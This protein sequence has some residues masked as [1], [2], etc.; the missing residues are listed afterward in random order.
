MKTKLSTLQKKLGKINNEIMHAI[1]V[2]DELAKDEALDKQHQ[3]N[4]GFFPVESHFVQNRLDALIGQRDAVQ[5]Q[6][7]QLLEHKNKCSI[8]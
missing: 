1:D 6:I 4:T 2:R 5:S 7:D 3:Y 8:L